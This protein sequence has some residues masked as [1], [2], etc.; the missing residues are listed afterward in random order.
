MYMP[1]HHKHVNSRLCAVSVVKPIEV[2]K[3]LAEMAAT[4]TGNVKNPQQ[5]YQQQQQLYQQKQQ[6]MA[7]EQGGRKNLILKAPKKNKNLPGTKLLIKL[8]KQREKENWLASQ[9]KQQYNDQMIN[10]ITDDIMHDLV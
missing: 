10:D 7:M 1:G 9:K 4:N 6:Q 5:I 8:A 2:F 3:P